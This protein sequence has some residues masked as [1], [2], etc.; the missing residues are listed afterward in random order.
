M[1]Q[2]CSSNQIAE[3]HRHTPKHSVFQLSSTYDSYDH[4]LAAKIPAI[5]ITEIPRNGERKCIMEPGRE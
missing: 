2:L 4:N 3:R 5:G 1:L